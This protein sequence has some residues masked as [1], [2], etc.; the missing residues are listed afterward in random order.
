MS[1]PGDPC[2]AC[3]GPTVRFTARDRAYGVDVTRDVCDACMRDKYRE[4]LTAAG[5]PA[6][7]IDWLV[8]SCPS[9]AH[10][11]AYRPPAT[12]SKPHSDPTPG[13]NGRTREA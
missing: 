7:D 1:E 8:A 6:R 2:P 5:A 4:V 11:E 9:L 10:A 3:S 12:P 13:E